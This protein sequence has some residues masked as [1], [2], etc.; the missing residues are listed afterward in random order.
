MEK[1][2]LTTGVGWVLGGPWWGLAGYWLGRKLDGRGQGRPVQ[3]GRLYGA[4]LTATAHL[5]AVCSSTAPGRWQEALAFWRQCFP[6]LPEAAADLPRPGGE[7]FAHR[8]PAEIA[9]ALGDLLAKRG[10][11]LRLWQA[12]Q[13]LS[14]RLGLTRAHAAPWL[15]ALAA[16]WGLTTGAR[17]AQRLPAM[18]DGLFPPQALA[19]AYGHLEV[20]VDAGWLEVKR[21]YQRLVKIHHPD[22]LAARGGIA[23]GG[24]D[25]D[26]ILAING[27]YELLKIWFQAC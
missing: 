23:S 24:A 15:M 26:R 14:C 20:N 18:V 17:Y 6:G 2:W 9:A 22:R 3:A 1:R 13:E 5:L 21:S 12:F 19:A 10:E 16:S 27:S 11:R 25:K 7:R 4:L 8:P